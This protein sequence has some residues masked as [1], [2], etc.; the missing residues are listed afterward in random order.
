[1]IQNFIVYRRVGGA[2]L[3]WLDGAEI[4]GDDAVVVGTIGAAAVTA[5]RYTINDAGLSGTTYLGRNAAGR[6]LIEFNN[7]IATTFTLQFYKYVQG[8]E[9][10]LTR[11]CRFTWCKRSRWSGWGTD[12]TDGVDGAA[13]AG[14]C[15]GCSL[16]QDGT[17]S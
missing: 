3:I 13:G 8:N 1:M 10:G 7:T 9:N 4:Y 14:R 2:L 17:G 11:P 5:Q 16:V 12:G 6:A 15:G